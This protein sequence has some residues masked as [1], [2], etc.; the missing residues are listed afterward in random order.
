MQLKRKNG[1]ADQRSLSSTCF[2]CNLQQSCSVTRHIKEVHAGIP[3]AKIPLRLPHPISN[4]YNMDVDFAEGNQSF[5][6]NFCTGKRKFALLNFTNFKFLSIGMP[7]QMI[8]LTITNLCLV[9]IRFTK[10]M[11]M[12]IV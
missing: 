6:K 8:H 3:R 11:Q 10:N 2:I 9:M 5:K 12:K 4:D 1:I 7:T